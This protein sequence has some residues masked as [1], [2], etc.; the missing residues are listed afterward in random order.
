MRNLVGDVIHVFKLVAYLGV[1]LIQLFLSSLAKYANLFAAI[2]LVG[3]YIVLIGGD[4]VQKI[5]QEVISYQKQRQAVEEKLV[6]Y[7][8]MMVIYPT[9][10]EILINAG[11]AACQ[12]NL[13]S[14]CGQ[15]LAKAKE[16]NPFHSFFSN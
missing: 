7:Q 11:L 9:N 16:I 12:L 8:K 1:F 5:S 3:L 13:K 2:G 4:A 6:T 10:S 14:E 15:Y